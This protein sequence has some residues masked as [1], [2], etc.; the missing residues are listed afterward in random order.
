VLS[1]RPDL[2]PAPLIQELGKL[3]DEL[4]PVEFNQIRGAMEDSL[5]GSLEE[6]FAT[7][8]AMPIAA[9]SLSQVHRGVLR[10][11]GKVVCVKVQRPGIRHSIESDLDILQAIADR[12]HERAEDLKTYDLPGLVRVVRRSLLQEIDFTREARNMKMARQY[13]VGKNAVYVPAVYESYSSY[14]V[15]VMEYINGRKLKDIESFPDP[16]ALAQKGLHSAIKQILEDGFFHADP[17]PGNMIVSDEVGLCLMDWGMVGRLTDQDRD[18]LLDLLKA[19]VEKDPEALGYALLN[20]TCARAPI[21]VRSLERDLLDVLDSFYSVPIK[22]VH[23]G[24]LLLTIT[25][26]LR[27]YRLQL[28]ADFVIMVKALV[29][30]EGTARQIYPDL[31]V[32]SEAEEYVTL[33]AS[34]KL[35]PEYAWRR[36]RT[37]L[38]SMLTLKR[39]IPRKLGA[40]VDKAEQGKMSLRFKHENLG[41][42]INTLEN[43]SSRLAFS[44]IIAA[45]I[46]GSSTI[47]TTGIGPR[48]L[49]FPALGIV[50]YLI[51]G[52]LGLWLVFNIIR[53]RRY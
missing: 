17:H 38:L 6:V 10:K 48:L 49:G 12:L 32:I 50:G 23:I 33:L 26:L 28:P 34:R 35:N 39:E 16:Y 31:D 46:I 24:Q 45:L 8:D 22:S 30:A 51:S 53:T 52:L 44:I 27:D 43:I 41:D 11:E 21:D 9:A 25:K 36:I 2:L 47:I 5:P 29:T 13:A 3:Q 4:P 20:L 19:I 7:L 14:K 1:L 37:A 42:L 40:I 18:E 15:L